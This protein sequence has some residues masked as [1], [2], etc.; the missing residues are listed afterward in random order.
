[1]AWLNR[2]DVAREKAEPVGWRRWCSEASD[3]SDDTV[4]AR[5]CGN[6][7]KSVLPY[8]AGLDKSRVVR[9]PE[10]VA[11]LGVLWLALVG[12][13]AMGVARFMRLGELKLAAVPTGEKRGVI[14]RL[15][16]LALGLSCDISRGEME[17]VDAQYEER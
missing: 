9:Q 12:G 2:L 8:S 10:V 11:R 15:G 4:T 17:V 16:V 5:P 7:A 6:T 13:E 3:G 14:M 1:M